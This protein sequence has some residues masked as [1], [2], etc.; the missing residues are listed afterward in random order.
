MRKSEIRKKSSCFGFRISDFG[1]ASSDRRLSHQVE[2]G[3]RG[4]VNADQRG[5][6]DELGEVLQGSGRLV[7]NEDNLDTGQFAAE[8]L[9]G[10]P[11]ALA[12]E[13]RGEDD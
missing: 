10:Q 6:S 11:A 8:L 12:G 7:G 2:E 4:A 5:G 13:V 9:A 3:G 1:F